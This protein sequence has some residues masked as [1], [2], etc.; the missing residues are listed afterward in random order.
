MK[1]ALLLFHITLLIFWS[2]TGYLRSDA[3]FFAGLGV[4][5]LSLVVREPGRG[6]WRF[7][8]LALLCTDLSFSRADVFGLFCGG[9]LLG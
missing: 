1:K 2:S 8:L 9:E 4:L 7:G 5:G 3:M 6:T